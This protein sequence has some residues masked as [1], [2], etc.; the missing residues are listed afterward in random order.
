MVFLTSGIVTA[1]LDNPWYEEKQVPNMGLSGSPAI[2][3]SEA[4]VYCFHQGSVDNNV[5]LCTIMYPWGQGFSNDILIPNVKTL[6]SPALVRYSNDYKLYCFHRGIGNTVSYFTCVPYSTVPYS[7]SDKQNVVPF[8]VT[9]GDIQI[10][11][12]STSGTPAVTEFNGKL[13]CFYPGSV[14]K[15]VLLYTTFDGKTWT[16][17]KQVPNMSLS[18]SPSVAVYGGK[19][20]CFYQGSVDNNALLYITFDGNKWDA[21][22]TLIPNVKTLSSP[23]LVV[24]GDLYCFHRG[25]EDTVSYFTLNDLVD[26]HIPNVGTSGTPA[27]STYYGL[28]CFYPGSMYKNVLLYTA[29]PS[30][31]VPR[32]I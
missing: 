2:I 4:T 22:D 27:V 15:N 9:S 24:Y 3:T 17:D 20:Y 32:S 21:H 5:L 14:D 25:I 1:A 28:Y 16:K 12:V 29:S 10:P 30:R 13:Y 18:G 19:L 23:A 31:L 8:T 7:T 26:E 11:N 6:S